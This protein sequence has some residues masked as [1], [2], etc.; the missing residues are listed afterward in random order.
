VHAMPYHAVRTE[1]F[2]RGKA[3]T[4]SNAEAA[5]DEAVSGAT[6]LKYNKWKIPIAKAM[7]KRSLLACAL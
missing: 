4:E 1:D 5:A 6:A 2:I 7:V 3:I